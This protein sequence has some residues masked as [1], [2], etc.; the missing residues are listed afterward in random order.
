MKKH[1]KL[2]T[3]RR[4]SYVKRHTGG[5]QTNNE[6]LIKPGKG[7][8]KYLGQTAMNKTCQTRQNKKKGEKRKEWAAGTDYYSWNSGESGQTQTTNVIFIKDRLP[9]NWGTT[10]TWGTN[11][12]ALPNLIIVDWTGANVSTV[13]GSKM[14]AVRVGGR[15]LENSCNYVWR[16][17]GG[18]FM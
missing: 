7:E 15:T 14:R 17:R 16:W 8:K 12:A 6:G 5:A 2:N 4:F 3:M 1:P 11:R 9:V 10:Q 13:T 18:C